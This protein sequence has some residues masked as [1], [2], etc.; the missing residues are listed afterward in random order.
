MAVRSDAPVLQVHTFTGGVDPVYTV[1]ADR[2]LLVKDARFNRGSGA[3]AVVFAFALDAGGN[4][5]GTLCGLTYDANGIA[6]CDPPPWAVLTEGQQLA[7][8]GTAGDTVRAWISGALL[9]GDPT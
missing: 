9:F 2:T 4:I 8:F 5:L 1:P 3:G 7:L 6:V